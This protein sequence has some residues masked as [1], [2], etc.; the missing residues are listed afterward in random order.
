MLYPVNSRESSPLLL[1]ILIR[2]GYLLLLEI[3]L[4]MNDRAHLNLRKL[5]RNFSRIQRKVD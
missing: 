4:E 2:L 1:S 3:Q 5:Y